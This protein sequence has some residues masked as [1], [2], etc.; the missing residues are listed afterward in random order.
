MK[1][2]EF[3]GLIFALNLDG[4]GGAEHIPSRKI[5]AELSQSSTT[6]VHLDYSAEGVEE[7]LC[8]VARLD[9]PVAAALVSEEPR[10]RCTPH[11]N[12]LIIVLRGV[13]SNPEQ[14]RE[15][16][17][18]IR[19]WIE[20]NTIISMRQRRLLSPA[21]IK[22]QLEAGCGPANEGELL[23]AL[24][25]RM[26]TFISEVVSDL[27]DKMDTLE[28][29]G[30]RLEDRSL[31]TRLSDLRREAI[32]VRRY[33]SPQRDAMSTL[34]TLRLNWLEDDFQIHMREVAD[35]TIRLI[36]DLDAI[37]E[38]G[39]VT[40]EELTNRIAERMN[41]IMYFLALVTGIFLPL[42]LLTGL[43]GINVGGLPGAANP[44][45]FWW[46]CGLLAALAGFQLW[47]YKKMKW[48]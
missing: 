40:N 46:V 34:S 18:S 33:L 6:W 37:R 32:I 42:G 9:A 17:V 20:Q 3:K 29:S 48:M 23:V 30:M 21:L 10:P 7:W 11:R 45:A 26:T 43:L 28:E 4:Q 14:D 38:R 24:S 12:G 25:G 31:R 2:S 36:E 8:K 44:A 22:E 19:I 41:R 13:N 16:M 35:R 27:D 5:R 1:Q 15:D 39:M 47:L